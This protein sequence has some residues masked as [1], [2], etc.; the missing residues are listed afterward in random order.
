MFHC[1]VFATGTAAPPA[2]ELLISCAAHRVTTR[3]PV[4]ASWQVHSAF[5]LVKRAA[6]AGKTVVVV[7]LGDTRAERSG[8]DV[9]KVS[10]AT[11][12]VEG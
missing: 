3:R 4:P 2:D 12:G 5:R 1:A 8:L 11:G 6:D 9:L 10:L 7:N